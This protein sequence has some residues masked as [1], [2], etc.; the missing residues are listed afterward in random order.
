V[1]RLYITTEGEST[2]GTYGDRIFVTE[3][4]SIVL[5]FSNQNKHLT[6]KGPHTLGFPGSFFEGARNQLRWSHH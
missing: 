6:D 4:M 1:S 2:T 3:I 5:S